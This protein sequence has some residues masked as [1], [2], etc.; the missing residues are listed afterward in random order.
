MVEAIRTKYVASCI[1]CEVSISKGS[2]VF[3]VKKTNESWLFLC[4][5]E[6]VLDY[7]HNPDDSE[8]EEEDGCNISETSETEFVVEK[9]TDFKGDSSGSKTKWLFLVHWVDFSKPS[10]EPWNN[11]KDTVA[12][13]VFLRNTNRTEMMCM[14]DSDSDNSDDDDDDEPCLPIGFREQRRLAKEK[15][16]LESE[17][18]YLVD[19]IVDFKGNPSGPKSKWKVLV[20][21]VGYSEDENTWEPF[22]EFVGNI[23]LGRFLRDRG[24]TQLSCFTTKKEESVNEVGMRTRNCGSN[25]EEEDEDEIRG[26]S[27]MIDYNTVC[28]EMADFIVPDENS[29]TLFHK[30]DGPI[31]PHAFN[32][33]SEENSDQIT[34]LGIQ[35]LV[36]DR[37]E[38]DE[39]SDEDDLVDSEGEET[40]DN[41][42][43]KRKRGATNFDESLVE[44]VIKELEK[45]YV[46][47]P[48]KKKKISHT[49]LYCS[50]CREFLSIDSFSSAQQKKKDSDKKRVCLKHS[51]TSAYNATFNSVLNEACGFRLK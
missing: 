31:L 28:E 27:R 34:T 39:D 1:C 2:N 21:W 16:Q 29:E 11:V 32:T 23:K 45:R 43:Q 19:K 35:E 24:L 3:G 22:E 8:A 49:T 47:V 36:I 12:I 20:Q 7:E 41:E 4:S 15:A 48:R 5:D 50:A 13:R 40:F 17:E 42:L 51:S 9:I 37:K 33:D 30:C 18:G 6:C 14:S 10:W 25:E 38:T 46:L 44:A 26:C